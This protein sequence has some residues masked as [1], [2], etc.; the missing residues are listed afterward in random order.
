LHFGLID[1]AI[2]ISRSSSSFSLLSVSI[3]LFPLL[4]VH[5]EGKLTQKTP[6]GGQ[7]R[8]SLVVFSHSRLPTIDW[9]M[10]EVTTIL[11]AFVSSPTIRQ[12]PKQ[13]TIK[14]A[15]VEC[16]SLFDTSKSAHQ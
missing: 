1:F 4:T 2:T 15:I 9:P 10:T 13:T 6:G 16:F 11:F 7:G 12:T 14:T 8:Q 3:S 5:I